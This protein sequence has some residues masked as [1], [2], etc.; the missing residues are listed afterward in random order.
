MNRGN[1]DTENDDITRGK[2]GSNPPSSLPSN[3]LVVS[4]KT[5]PSFSGDDG[6]LNILLDTVVSSTL[7][8]KSYTQAGHHTHAAIE[9][10]VSYVTDRIRMDLSRMIRSKF[11][12]F[13]SVGVL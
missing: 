2:E 6:V 11:N 10:L 9:S 3:T 4:S 1:L 5:S 12:S 13:F 8:P 7:V